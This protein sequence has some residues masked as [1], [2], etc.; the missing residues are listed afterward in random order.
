MNSLSSGV[1]LTR[2]FFQNSTK[3]LGEV[4]ALRSGMMMKIAPI[5]R[6]LMRKNCVAAGNAWASG[7]KNTNAPETISHRQLIATTSCV[8]RVLSE[9]RLMRRVG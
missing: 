3:P 1:H 5:T 8:M 2:Y 4:I 6:W 9:W 7:G